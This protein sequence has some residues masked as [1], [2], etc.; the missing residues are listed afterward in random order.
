VFAAREPLF[1]NH[2]QQQHRLILVAS[3]GAC[4]D[5]GVYGFVP[6]GADRW[7]PPAD[8]QSASDTAEV[9]PDADDAAA[10]AAADAMAYQ[11]HTRS[12]RVVLAWATI[13]QQHLAAHG[14]QQEVRDFVGCRSLKASPF[15]CLHC[16]YRCPN[17]T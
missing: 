16:R 12:S 8:A 5:G 3:N 11:R 7:L 14:L 1:D 15:N 13:N 4:G 9:P 17:I 10:A 2:F 6:E